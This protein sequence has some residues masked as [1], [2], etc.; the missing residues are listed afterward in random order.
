MAIFRRLAGGTTLNLSVLPEQDREGQIRE[1][2]LNRE[3][4]WD[5]CNPHQPQGLPLSVKLRAGKL[6]LSRFPKQGPRHDFVCRHYGFA[7]ADLKERGWAKSVVVRKRHGGD[8]LLIRPA[9]SVFSV[10]GVAENDGRVWGT[11]ER[12][13]N[14][15]LA[16]SATLGGLTCLMIEMACLH[17]YVPERNVSSA[18]YWRRMRDAAKQIDL[19][20]LPK[21]E[22][23][24]ADKILLPVGPDGTWSKNNFRSLESA[25]RY[26]VICL[27]ELSSGQFPGPG[28]EST[29]LFGVFDV[30]VILPASA[31]ERAK[32]RF[33]YLEPSLR[34]GDRVLVAGLCTVHDAEGKGPVATVDELFALPLTPGGAPA[35]SGNEVIAFSGLEARRRAYRVSVVYDGH[36][37]FGMRPD[38]EI[39]DME[40]MHLFEVFGFSSA[41]Y[42]EAMLKKLAV[43]ERKFPGRFTYWDVLLE[44]LETALDRLPRA[45]R[46]F[47][48]EMMQ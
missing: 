4:I 29:G 20:G 48:F 10:T 42:R 41:Q 31:V 40:L 12:V 39:L 13:I 46:T 38:A 32:R 24:L 21:S 27:T 18:D 1:A 35:F 19:R 9:F 30:P 11:D 44:S 33:R 7:S 47:D 26:R 43:L 2:R 25:G 5:Y 15:P 37:Y 23:R 14:Q 22:W 8:S 16:Q 3:T 6:V 34:N 36:R 45:T 28:S 17:T